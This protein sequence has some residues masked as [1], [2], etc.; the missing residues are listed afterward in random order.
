MQFGEVGGEKH[1]LEGQHSL[2]DSESALD[3]PR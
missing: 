2:R 1:G 3:V